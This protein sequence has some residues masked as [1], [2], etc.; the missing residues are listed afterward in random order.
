[1]QKQMYSVKVNGE[2]LYH[3]LFKNQAISIAKEQATQGNQVFV[4]W[5]RKTDSQQGYLNSDGNHEITG[6]AW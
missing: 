1:M 2:I 5:F 6:T 3:D 4:T